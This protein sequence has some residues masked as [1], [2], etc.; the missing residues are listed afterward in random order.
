MSRRQFINRVSVSLPG[1]RYSPSLDSIVGVIVSRRA[2]FDV[3]IRTTI[4]NRKDL[5]RPFVELLGK[6]RQVF[7]SVEFGIL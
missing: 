3:L 7:G 4:R 2:K 6:R 5:L 1:Q